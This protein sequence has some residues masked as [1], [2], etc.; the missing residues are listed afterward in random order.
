MGA[1]VLLCSIFAATIFAGV[2]E[3]IKD[4]QHA[5]RIKEY[6][7]LKKQIVK[8]CLYEPCEERRSRYRKILANIAVLEYE[9]RK[10]REL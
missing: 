2:Y 6:E 7:E 5:R 9:E 8:R 1:W 4:K 3:Y 10:S